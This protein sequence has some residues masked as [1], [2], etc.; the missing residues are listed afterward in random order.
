M[1]LPIALVADKDISACRHISS[2]L[3]T[4]GVDSQI[5]CTAADA[6]VALVATD[7]RYLFT[8]LRF[9]DRDGISLIADANRLRP[10]I[11]T[12]I[13]SHDTAGESVI[14]ALRLGVCDYVFKPVSPQKILAALE[15]ANA[16]RP[17]VPII[18]SPLMQPRPVEPAA[19]V[20]PP[21]ASPTVT[22]PLNGDLRSIE[23]QLVKEVIWRCDGNKAA[24]ARVLGMHRRTLYRMLAQ[25]NAPVSMRD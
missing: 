4:A 1:A 24:A 12:V 11:S 10:R 17:H 5:V 9:N 18:E 19:P 14:Q 21:K 8:A 20:D 6:G 2:I 7:F 15:R 3:K 22:L 16:H 23:R 25:E 13:V